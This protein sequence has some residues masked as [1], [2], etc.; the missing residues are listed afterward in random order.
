MIDVTDYTADGSLVIRPMTYP[1]I[2]ARIM[3]WCR[4]RTNK[5]R[6]RAAY[7]TFAETGQDNNSQYYYFCHLIFE[8]FEVL[9]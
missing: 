1:S 7:I 2:C 4:K 5:P 9:I 8:V 3:S 6:I